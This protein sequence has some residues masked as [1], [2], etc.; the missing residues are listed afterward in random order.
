MA[1][2]TVKQAAEWLGVAPATIY[3]LC[4]SRVLQHQRI[5]VGRGCIRIREE[6]LRA[7]LDRAT[8]QTDASAALPP[9]EDGASGSATP[10]PGGLPGTANSQTNEKEGR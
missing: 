8:V 9:A 2:F 4:S 5:G 7:Y 3:S 1:I 6:D 10:R